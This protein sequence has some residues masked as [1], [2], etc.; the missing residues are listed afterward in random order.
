MLKE[1]R[2]ALDR[3]FTQDV[4]QSQVKTALCNACREFG[5]ALN[6]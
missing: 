5:P 6:L 1:M 4:G 3:A 2:A